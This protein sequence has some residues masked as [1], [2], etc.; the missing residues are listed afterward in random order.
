MT[1]IFSRRFIFVL[2][3]CFRLFSICLIFS[4]II[5][6]SAYNI[7]LPGMGPT[8]WFTAAAA[9]DHHTLPVVAEVDSVG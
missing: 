5:R 6:A 4:E 2:K 1:I 3:Q 7:A 8:S 9:A